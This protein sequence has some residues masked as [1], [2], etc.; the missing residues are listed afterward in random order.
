MTLVVQP[1]PPVASRYRSLKLLGRGGFSAV[2][3]ARDESLN[4]VVA[5]KVMRGRYETSAWARSRLLFEA[6]VTAG[7]PPGG[8]N[9]CTRAP[10][11]CQPRTVSS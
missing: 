9:R 3:L 8:A 1:I 4:R 11:R 5:L 7:S 2:Y 6:E 10:A